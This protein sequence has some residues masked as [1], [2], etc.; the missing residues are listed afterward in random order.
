MKR[1]LGAALLI[2]VAAGVAVC[3]TAWA[4]VMVPLDYRDLVAR[5][6][7]VM[8]GEVT[9]VSTQWNR[10]HSA[11]VTY[12][13]LCPTRT[14]KGAAT[15]DPV[16]VER[17]GGRIGDVAHI[18][19]GSP[20][21]ALG[22]TALMFVRAT[23][24]GTYWTVG[25]MQG[26][27]SVRRGVVV[28]T[29]R[30]VD[31]TAATISALAAERAGN[32]P[33]GRASSPAL[34]DP[35]ALFTGDL[36]YEPLVEPT[37][38]A[39]EKWNYSTPI[40]YYVNTTGAGAPNALA[41]VQAGHGAWNSVSRSKF[42]FQY[43]GLTSAGGLNYND[44][45]NVVSWR[46]IPPEQS[47]AI[48]VASRWM[49]GGYIVQCD[50]ILDV[51][52]SWATDGSPS[53]LDIQSVVA[54]ESGHWLS[55]GDL[56]AYS[57]RW[58][59]MYYTTS[60]G[61][62]CKRTLHRDDMNG[63]AYL[64]PATISVSYS[65]ISPASVQAGVTAP[66]QVTVTNTSAYPI[67]N[68]WLAVAIWNPASQKVEG[69]KAPVADP[70]IGVF[71]LIDFGSAQGL[72]LAAGASRTFTANYAFGTSATGHH[73]TAG[74]YTLKF[75]AWADGYP[76]LASEDS[77]QISSIVGSLQSAGLT[78]TSPVPLSGQVI[79][80]GTGVALNG[81]TVTAYKG[82]TP[83]ASAIAQAPYGVYQFA[84]GLLADTY[85]VSAAAQGHVRQQKWN[86][87]V[88][89]SGTTYVNFNLA[90]SGKLKG[91]VRDKVTGAGIIGAT[92][93]AR[94]GGITW[95]TA[96]TTAP[97]G[98][99]EIDTDL[100]AGTFVVGASKTGYIGFGRSGIVVTA[101]ATTYVNFPLQPQ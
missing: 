22:E 77:V 47:G 43:A 8:V 92:V 100:A 57:D 40:R 14:L 94:S 84:P 67:Y 48:A 42:Q 88:T 21:F 5:A 33:A 87:V 89:S 99:Y 28:R 18:V 19:D 70:D 90:V 72:T 98:I 44:S 9:G 60:T 56:S 13:T 65:A 73:Y 2:A 64:Y 34:L 81:A 27:F 51:S 25:M 38:V 32:P 76:G 35:S 97:W 75:A 17:T 3:G 52:S 30:S 20:Q 6:D 15:L 10:D 55:L 101:G 54:H 58:K 71:G 36:A 24:R 62:L 59:T 96:V 66:I 93:V 7:R 26:K 85:T 63:D 4:T 12:V 41:A 1:C 95:A 11:I 49:T 50:T 80:R 31:D 37:Y 86:V 53:L 16:T 82:G 91:Q 46:T 45:Q 74:A 68:L 39:N 83:V 61:E 79:E 23:G 78:I 29:G 69:T